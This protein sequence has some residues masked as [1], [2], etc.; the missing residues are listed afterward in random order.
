MLSRIESLELGKRVKIYRKCIETFLSSKYVR[1]ETRTI[2]G[3]IF[4]YEDLLNVCYYVVPIYGTKR[5][6][7]K[8]YSMYDVSHL[9][10]D[11]EMINSISVDRLRYVYDYMEQNY[12]N[13]DNIKVLAK[14]LKV[15]ITDIPNMA[16]EYAIDYLKYN[17][18]DYN[19][20]I[21]CKKRNNIKAKM[22]YWM[23]FDLLLLFNDEKDIISIVDYSSVDIG[24][25]NLKKINSYINANH[26]DKSLEEQSLIFDEIRKKFDLYL[27]SKRLKENQFII[28]KQDEELCK[29]REFLEQY[30]NTSKNYKYMV[31]YC[32]AI[33]VSENSLGSMLDVLKN[34]NLEYDRI[35]YGLCMKKIEEDRQIGSSDVNYTARIISYFVLNGVITDDGVRDFDLIDFYSLTDLSIKEIGMSC[36]KI[37]QRDDYIKVKKF[38]NVSD[39]LNRTLMNS[40]KA[41]DF[42]IEFDCKKDSDGFPIVGTGRRLTEEE[43]GRILD[44]FSEY[45]IPLYLFKIAIDRLKKGVKIEDLVV[46]YNYDVKKKIRRN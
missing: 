32:R 19:W 45:N 37:L 36:Q 46:N 4:S 34:S 13:R 6:I 30:V 21:L 29:A 26:N 22:S 44:L 18:M 12:N 35:L 17:Y 39:N 1:S 28:E 16:R 31:E 10:L 7:D 2:E 14:K 8:F 42:D 38:L 9:S 20:H 40:K 15:R 41:V 11:E 25:Y 23:L 43:R 33:C 24:N 5:E 3:I 27:K